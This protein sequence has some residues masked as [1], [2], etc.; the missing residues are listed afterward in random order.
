M[1]TV[2]LLC[3]DLA[4]PKWGLNLEELGSFLE[5]T[6]TSVAIEVFPDL[7]HH[8]GELSSILAHRHADRA[9]FGLCSAGYSQVALQTSARKAGLDPLSLETVLLGTLCGMVHPQPQ[10]TQKA[11]CLLS[12]AVAKARAFQGSQ[13]EQAKLCLMSPDLKMSRRSLFTVPPMSYRP[14]PGIRQEQCAAEAGCDLCATACPRHAL[15]KIGQRLFLDRTRCESCGLC[16]SACPRR[17]IDLPG[18]SLSQ[19]ES[20]LAALLD[21]AT[22]DLG[23]FGVLFTCQK[24]IPKLEELAGQGVPY[25]HQW[26]PMAV[27]CLGMVTPAWIL[28]SLAH[29]A[30]E[31]ALLSCGASCTF[32]QSPTITGRVDFC[33]TLLRLLGQAP[34]LV[35]LTA[36]SQTKRLLQIL[37]M[38]PS[39]H[40]NGYQGRSEKPLCLASPAG[41]FMAI[42]HLAS[43]AGA[44]S[45]VSVEHAHSPFGLLDLQ[46]DRCTGCLACVERC[47]TGALASESSGDELFITYEASRCIGCGICADSCP[48]RADQALKAN[49]VTDLGILSGDR[50]ALYRDRAVICESCKRVISSRALMKRLETLLAEGGVTLGTAIARHCPSCRST[51]SAGVKPSR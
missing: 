32:K 4:N 41:A 37:E 34:D 50:V 43:A 7:C 5:G 8:L 14:V 48:E 35:R 15:Q 11:K 20:Q 16:L 33:R 24:A 6:F 10:A 18:W 13:P 21:A 46:S 49:K 17:A 30:R 47:P 26:L 51:F 12:A 42:Q 28:Q 2:V 36:V 29:G 38:P 40:G 31:V 19:L 22:L 9:V 1:M 25:S 39:Q 44:S 3:S 23:H 27:P 45:D